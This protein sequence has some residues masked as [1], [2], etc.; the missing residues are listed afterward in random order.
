MGT[1][2]RVGGMA[3]AGLLLTA[4]VGGPASAQATNSPETFVGT[5]S[6]KALGLTVAGQGLTAGASSVSADSTVK[7]VAQGTGFLSPLAS[8]QTEKLEQVGDGVKSVAETCDLSSGALPA[9]VSTL[10]D[11]GAACSSALAQVEG[12]LPKAVS[13]GKVAGLDVNLSVLTEAAGIDVGTLAPILDPVLGGVG[14]LETALEENLGQQIDLTDTLDQVV[15]ALVETKTLEIDLGPSLSQTIADGSK[16]TSSANAQAGSI[17]LFPLGAALETVAG[18]E[19]KPIVEIVIGSS[20]ATSTYDRVTGKSA[21]AFDPAIVTIRV[22]T[23]L[24]DN[25]GQVTGFDLSEVAIAPN[26]SAEQLPAQLA[27]LGAVVKACSDAA[28]EFCILEGTPLETRIAVA[29][30]RTIQNADGSVGAV[31][32]AVKIHALKNI[33][34]VA[35]QLEGGILLE[36]A[37]AQAGIGGAP[38][39]SISVPDLPRELPRTGG[40]ALPLLA[41]GGIAVALGARRAVRASR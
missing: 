22:N 35:P 4:V 13:T 7:A 2:R 15:T 17:K 26:L 20:S 5:A 33:G 36:L 28:N 6:A 12:G 31:A 8:Q 27:P 37:H 3:V 41:V 38:A 9:P 14:T 10:L 1:I 40:P 11:L 32:D 23:P 30:G 19:M 39:V 16:V 34:E 25:L 24:T 29:S 18:V 21:A